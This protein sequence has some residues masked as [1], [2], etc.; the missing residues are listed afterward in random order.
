MPVNRWIAPAI[1][2]TLAGWGDVWLLAYG[3]TRLRA[4]RKIRRAGSH[5]R[6]WA[7]HGSFGCHGGGTMLDPANLARPAMIADPGARYCPY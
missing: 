1:A 2:T 7:N 4:G 6:I 3:A 5:R